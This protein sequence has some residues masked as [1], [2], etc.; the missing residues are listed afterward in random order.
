MS[1]DETN[2]QTEAQTTNGEVS[3]VTETTE[4]EEQADEQEDYR[5]KLNA[6]NRFLEK[7]GYVFKDGRWVKPQAP[8]VQRKEVVQAKQSGDTL[9]LKDQYALTSA[10]VHIDDLDEVVEAARLL[11]M[12]IADA[13]KHPVVK[14]ILSAKADERKTAEAT[15]TKP[16]R[17]SQKKPDPNEILRKASQGEIPEKGSQE[18]EDLFWA[19]RGG[20]R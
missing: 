19:K 13:L 11:K 2:E 18:A 8:V 7:E 15:S 16:A 14:G 5:G 10:Q 9:S 20:K 4:T 1:T 6:T 3:E 12:P 17:P